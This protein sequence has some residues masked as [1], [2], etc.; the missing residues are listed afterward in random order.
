MDSLFRTRGSGVSS[1]VETTI[2]PQ[3]LAE[4]DG[5][6]R[7]D[8]VIVIGA[9]NRE[10]MIDPAILR[11][12]RLDAKIKIE[13]P[14]AESARDIFSK[15]LVETLPL[16]EHDLAVNGGD[17]DATVEAMITAAVERMYSEMEENRFLEVTYQG[18]DKEILYFKDF[19]SGAMIQNIVDRAKKL[20]IKDFLTTGQKGIRVEHLLAAASTSSR[21]TRTCPTRPTP[22]TGR[23]SRQEGR[24]D[25]LHPHPHQGQGRHRAGSLDRDGQHGPV[26]LRA[27]Y[28]VWPGSPGHPW[29]LDG[30]EAATGGLSTV[31]GRPQ[32][33]FRRFG[34]GRGWLA[35]VGRAGPANGIRPQGAPAEQEEGEHDRGHDDEAG[36]RAR[37]DARPQQHAD[38]HGREPDRDAG[39]DVERPDCRSDPHDEPADGGAD[40]EGPGRDER[41][42]P[43]DRTRR[44][45]PAPRPRRRGRAATSSDERDAAGRR[46]Q[47]GVAM[48]ARSNGSFACGGAWVGS[49]PSKSELTERPWWM[50]LIASAKRADDR[51]DLAARASRAGGGTVSVVTTSVIDRVVAQ[52]LDGLAGEEAVGADDRGLGGS[53][54][55]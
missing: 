29:P 52:P 55:P 5:V 14:D 3:L 2:V 54:R 20:A 22:T 26:P 6:E 49:T 13:R 50:R 38:E 21:R 39:R 11:P 8:N 23:A 15:Y 27:A 10:D 48:S 16:H 1:D 12:G 4:I 7:L 43:R 42:R 32:V 33:A 53:R 45:S 24:A 19:N 34:V 18:G 35:L 46:H 47:G 28:A 37:A 40:E 41:A 17:R 30:V 44:G 36:G 9:S 25:R 51:P 31:E